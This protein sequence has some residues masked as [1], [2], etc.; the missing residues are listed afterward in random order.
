MSESKPPCYRR[1]SAFGKRGYYAYT[2]GWYVFISCTFSASGGNQSLS[3][4]LFRRSYRSV[5]VL[6]CCGPDVS[7]PYRGPL[8]DRI[9]IRI[10]V[11]RSDSRELL[12]QEAGKSSSEL[13]E[14]VER[15]RAFREKRACFGGNGSKPG[16]SVRYLRDACCFSAETE[17][18]FLALAESKELSSSRTG[19]DAAFGANH[20]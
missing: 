8:L 19:Q 2:C 18:F 13:R 1:S 7:E 10:D 12:G 16:K 3:L 9:D 17:E 6:S 14:G 4:R 15:A 5:Q 11:W 20:R